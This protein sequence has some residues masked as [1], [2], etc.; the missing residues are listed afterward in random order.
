M[1][2]PRNIRPIPRSE[3][4]EDCESSVESALSRRAPDVR[5]AVRRFG[6]SMV[7]NQQR[8][9]LEI[10]NGSTPVDAIVAQTQRRAGVSTPSLRVSPM[11]GVLIG[12]FD[13]DS[14]VPIQVGAAMLHTTTQQSRDH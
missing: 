10:L 7:V 6:D 5:V 12:G 11:R 8:L 2:M 13:Q 3:W 1:T 4:D 9:A 14:L